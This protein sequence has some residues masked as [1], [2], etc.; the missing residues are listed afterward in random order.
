MST[1][2][3]N[4]A[5]RGQT[6]S[7]WRDENHLRGVLLRLMT[8]NLNIGKEDL[9][10]LYV[11]RVLQSEDLVEEAIRRCFANDLTMIVKSGL[12]IKK[13]RIHNYSKTRK[14]TREQAIKEVAEKIRQ[15]VL[16]DLIMPNGKKLR[17]CTGT[18]CGEFSSAYARLKDKVGRRIVGKVLSEKEIRSIVFGKG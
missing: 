18:E 16:L 8:D 7:T 10:S 2:N 17:D 1:E 14:Q 11:E 5:Q 6:R 4:P 9:E 15:T 13:S 12:Q 3:Y